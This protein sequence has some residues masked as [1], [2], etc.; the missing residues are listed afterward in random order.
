M[1]FLAGPIKHWWTCWG[2]PEHEDYVAW[3]DEVRSALI[4]AGYLTYAPWD[5]IKGT[6]DPRAQAINDIAIRTADL[7]LVMTPLGIPA[8]GTD[9]EV[10]FAHE[11]KTQVLHTWPLSGAGP[12]MRIALLL[13]RVRELIGLGVAYEDAGLTVTSGTPG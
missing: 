6:W 7:M 4:E 3:R 11:A 8:D 1:I 9:A 10:A 12:E 13:D 2:S 5:A